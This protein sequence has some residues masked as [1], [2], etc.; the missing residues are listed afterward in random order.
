MHLSARFAAF[1]FT[2][3]LAAAFAIYV[4]FWITVAIYGL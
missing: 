3:L 1:A 2:M 4:A